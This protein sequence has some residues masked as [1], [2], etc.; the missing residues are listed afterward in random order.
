MNHNFPKGKKD[1]A[2]RRDA[3]GHPHDEGHS[4]HSE[5][6]IFNLIL[7]GDKESFYKAYHILMSNHS[8]KE[9]ESSLRKSINLTSRKIHVPWKLESRNE[10]E[11]SSEEDMYL[12][13]FYIRDEHLI[14][15]RKLFFKVLAETAPITYFLDFNYAS[16]ELKPYTQAAVTTFLLAGSQND[17]LDDQYKKSQFTYSTFIYIFSQIY[18]RGDLDTLV[19]IGSTKLLKRIEF[20]AEEKLSVADLKRVLRMIVPY[21]QKRS[22]RKN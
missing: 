6:L 15:L 9:Y 14:S 21:S 12:P 4:I 13:S 11:G 17:L 2:A 16:S 1:E 7:N 22:K 19:E 18:I 20:I 8:F 10:T 5:N 3:S